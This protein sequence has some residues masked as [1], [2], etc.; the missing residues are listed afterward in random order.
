MVD[1]TPILRGG[2]QRLAAAFAFGALLAAA[3]AGCGNSSDESSTTTSPT[4]THTTATTHETETTHATGTAAGADTDAVTHAFVTFFSG[5]T[6]GATKITLVQ[7]GEAFADTINA[8]AN[9]PMA[10]GT[11]A[12]VSHVDM[13]APGH[14]T[15]TYTVLINGQPALTDQMGEAVQVDGTWKVSQSTF[16][17]LLTLEG[18][19]PPACA[20]PATPAPPTS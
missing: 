20:N 14:A 17:A 2:P 11:T 7:N 18:N 15:V 6:A 19:P 5:E 12:T 16:C 1:S 10:T 8:Q 3:V 9:S 4:T 13:D